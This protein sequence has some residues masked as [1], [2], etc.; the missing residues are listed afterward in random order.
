MSTMEVGGAE[1]TLRGGGE[2][3][4]VGERDARDRNGRKRM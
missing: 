1:V 4:V 3:M 2:E